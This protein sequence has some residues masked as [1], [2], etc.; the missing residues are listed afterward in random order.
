MIGKIAQVKFNDENSFL[1]ISKDWALITEKIL[2]N[3]KL[4]KLIYYTSPDA[5]DKENLSEEQKQSLINKNILCF[6]Y[7]PEDDDVSN[8]I[9]ILFDNFLPNETNPEYIDSTITLAII[10]NRENW[11]MADWQMR[12]YSIA[13]E[14]MNTLNHQSLAGIGRA[15]FIG[16]S[17]FVPSRHSFGLTMTFAVVNSRNLKDDE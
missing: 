4:L 7:V 14:I 8:Y 10:C 9:S 2:K 11:I 17:A 13:N 15:N 6:P 1:A 5:L 16:A 3:D 12:A